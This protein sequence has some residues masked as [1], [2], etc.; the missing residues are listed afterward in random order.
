VGDVPVVLV[1]ERAVTRPPG[2]YEM[3]ELRLAE[4]V[5]DRIAGV[6]RDDPNDVVILDDAAGAP[7]G[8]I[9]TR[10]DRRTRVVPQGVFSLLELAR[11]LA[12]ARNDE[13]AVVDAIRSTPTVGPQGAERAHPLE[14]WRVV[15]TC[16]EPEG[17]PPVSHRTVFTG[18][19][20]AEPAVM[21]GTP[22]NGVDVAL[23]ISA[24]SDLEP[25]NA[26]A[27]LERRVKVLL[28]AQVAIVTAGLLF[29]WAT[30]GLGLAAREAPGWLGLA[31]V[32]ALGAVTL[33]AVP[34]FAGNRTRGNADDTFELRRYYA[35]RI[36]LLSIAPA[37]SAGLFALALLVA[38]VG[39]ALAA[40]DALPPVSVAFDT[41]TEPVTAQV[42]VS[43]S[44]VATDEALHV[45][46]R[47]YPGPDDAGTVLGRITT[48]G[49][50]SGDVPLN[51]TIA[52]DPDARYLAVQ[53]WIGETGAEIALDT[54]PP[55]CTPAMP[56]GT[57]CTVVAVPT[58][59]TFEG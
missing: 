49:T 8:G 7:G 32:L 57:G 50:R 48:T 28:F 19:G 55:G 27:T 20:E 4:P 54:A 2:L 15:I 35:S 46:V 51:E 23:E 41:T 26:V 9:A 33:A 12:I 17:V 5:V 14:P 11:H 1:S 24:E 16:P 3:D 37:V 59:S 10:T 6:G 31:V 42:T 43:G 39:P 29:A 21:V 25:A 36:E 47:G 30:G 56:E 52:L 44:D 40:D 53:V 34:L 58:G 18:T 38:T 13:D 45:E 22:A